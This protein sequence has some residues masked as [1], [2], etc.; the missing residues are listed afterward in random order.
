M[1]KVTKENLFKPAPPK[2]AAKGDAT[3]AAARAI[4]DR[5][6]A[7]REAKTA[8]LRRARL[9]KE[10][11]DKEAAPAPAPRKSAKKAPKAR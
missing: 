8:R 4:I 3:T 10:A 6:T 11:A 7:E 2:A 5:E 1:Q 9:A